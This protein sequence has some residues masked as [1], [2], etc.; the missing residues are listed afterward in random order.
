MNVVW[1]PI[2]TGREPLSPVQAVGVVGLLD[3]TVQEF[4][5]TFWVDQAIVAS[6][7]LRALEGVAVIVSVACCT[8]M[9]D[10]PVLVPPFATQ[11]SL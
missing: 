2:A 7:P 10:T 11:L 4:G 8:V 6:V 3:V 9:I 1:T 5:V